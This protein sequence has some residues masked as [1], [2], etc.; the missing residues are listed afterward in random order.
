MQELPGQVP[1]QK[2][3]EVPPSCAGDAAGL[4]L[5]DSETWDFLIVSFKQH[6]KLQGGEQPHSVRNQ[7]LDTPR[8]HTTPLSRLI[9]FVKPEYDAGERLEARPSAGAGG[10]AHRHSEGADTCQCRK[11]GKCRSSVLFK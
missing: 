7:A 9:V 11:P 1:C 3:L 8:D 4:C 2:L 6:T 10:T 5:G